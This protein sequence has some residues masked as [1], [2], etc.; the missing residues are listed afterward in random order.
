[1]IDQRLSDRSSGVRYRSRSAAA[2]FVLQGAP[3]ILAFVILLGTVL[4]YIGFFRGNLHYW[5]GNFEWTS[6]IDSSLPLV[7]AAVGQTVVVI[8]RGLDLSVGGMID[9]TNS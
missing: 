2:H 8:T 7:F 3:L 4:L 5:P 9:L 1:M 6:L